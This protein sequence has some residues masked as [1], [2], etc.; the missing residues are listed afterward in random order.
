MSDFHVAKFTS[1]HASAYGVA[2]FN[3]RANGVGAIK[4]LKYK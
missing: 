1:C 3:N 4:W 2:M